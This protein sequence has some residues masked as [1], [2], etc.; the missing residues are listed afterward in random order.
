MSESLAEK[1]EV[2]EE[3]LEISSPDK[4]S[5]SQK[6]SEF[7]IGEQVG[8]IQALL[9][10]A[11]EPLSVKNLSDVTSLAE[12]KIEILLSSLIDRTDR[13]D[14]GFEVV[15][16]AG[17][18]Q[19]RT[20]PTY[21]SFIRE[22]RAEK[23]RRLSNAALETLAIIAY[24][25]PVV[26][27]DIEKIRGVDTTPTLKTLM[28]RELIRIVGHQSTAGQP[29]LYGTTEEFLKIFGLSSLS[30]L[31]TLRDL[32]LF[33]R[34]PGELHEDSTEAETNSASA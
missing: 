5:L 15:K 16:V 10:A 7:N 14:S 20:K 23:P 28:E 25:Q 6:V 12:D 9:F 31:P 1:I 2:T 19:L 21:G 22:L 27:S 33:E 17:K 34:E 29:A 11:S 3:T 30:E 13:P 8:L 26:K 18:F 4:I 24:R 32:A